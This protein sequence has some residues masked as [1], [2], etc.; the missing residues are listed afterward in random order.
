MTR[1]RGFTLVELLVVIAIIAILAAVLIPALMAARERANQTKCMANL[2]SLAIALNE[3]A[4]SNRGRY[5][6]YAE[7]PVDTLSWEIGDQERTDDGIWASR[8]DGFL[9]GGGELWTCPTYD[10]IGRE[11]REDLASAETGI[12]YGINNTL[13]MTRAS[14]GSVIG[15]PASAPK[16]P[17]NTVLLVENDGYDAGG[18]LGG[19]PSP[20][21]RH[22]KNA[23]FFNIVYC[24][25]N[26]DT[27]EVTRYPEDWDLE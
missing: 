7:T 12:P 5:P 21:R 27:V 26:T 2:R 15:R 11:F 4:D 10:E 3:Y 22:L 19:E 6:G 13:S 16:S 18:A 9:G 25:S 17:R 20:A 14:D 23:S 8:I 1:T 24:D